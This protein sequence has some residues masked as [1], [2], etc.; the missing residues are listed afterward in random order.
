M[1]S[2]LLKVLLLLKHGMPFDVLIR[3]KQTSSARKH[4]AIWAISGDPRV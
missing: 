4:R 2:D 1:L 3:Y